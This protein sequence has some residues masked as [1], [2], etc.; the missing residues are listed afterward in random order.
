MAFDPA[1]ET[2]AAADKCI[3]ALSDARDALDE[4]YRA[5]DEAFKGHHNELG[6]EARKRLGQ[7]IW[8]LSEVRK[9]HEIGLA[10]QQPQFDLGAMLQS[11]EITPEDWSSRISQLAQ[12]DAAR[13]ITD[14]GESLETL[15]EAFYWIA[16]RARNAIRALPKMG[17]FKAVGV[18][19]T[20]NWL[21]EHPDKPQSRVLITSFGWGGA[22]G[23]VVKAMR[24]DHQKDT[25]VDRGLFVN[26]LDFAVELQ[27]KA[28]RSAL[29]LSA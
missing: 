2:R 13:L 9:H 1:S 21:L 3:E 4:H 16:S 18:R 29:E 17:G 14:S 12:A 26:A 15:T 6:V 11:G 25:W 5:C 8:L 7:M 22:C 24:L 28:Q 10:A 23:P 20:R 19:D 27:R